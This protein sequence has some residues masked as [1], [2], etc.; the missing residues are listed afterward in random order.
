LFSL[1]FEDMASPYGGSGGGE[2]GVRRFSGVASTIE[3]D[4]FKRDFTM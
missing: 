3:V 1:D 4:D 2:R